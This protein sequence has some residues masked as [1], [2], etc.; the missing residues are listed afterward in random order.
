MKVW[1]SLLATLMFAAPGFGP[2]SPPPLKLVGTIPLPNID[3]RIDHFSI[4]LQHQAIFVAALG[5]NAVVSVDLVHGKVLGSIPDL[6]EPQGLLYVPENGHLYIANGGDGSLR[7]YEANTLKQIKSVVL[8]DDADNI[9]YDATTKTIWIGYGSG[10]MAALDLDGN[11][12]FDIPV[13]E[14]PESFS[15]EQHGNKM[16]VN[17][18]RKKEV[19]VVDRTA[20][21]VT[22]F[23]GTGSTTGNYPMAF[24]EAN[25]RIF[26]GCR[27][28][29]RLL[30]LDAANGKRV[31]ELDTVSG[32]DDLFYDGANH[33]IY[34]LGGG[35]FVVT[36]N[37]S[38]ANTY[39]EISRIAT[40]AGG[41]TGLFV[42]ELKEL[43]VAIPRK[44]SQDAF[45]QIYQVQ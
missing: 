28:P 37:Q 6:K 43:L 30:V 36:Y 29:A 32:T 8:G 31:A 19:A 39:S 16:Y 24:D 23:Y 40:S 20:K 12:L 3:G 38:N 22:A 42:P 27:V 41:R 45:V 7:I 2:D 17:V 21:K 9:R 11:K 10:A 33:R 34:V 1:L 15:L 14:H 35:G 26:L 5:A 13:G 25:A 44:G 18:P 4:D